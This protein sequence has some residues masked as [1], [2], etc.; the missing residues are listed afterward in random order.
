M[1]PSVRWA[2][3][4]KKGGAGS[5]MKVQCD[6]E[7]DGNQHSQPNPCIVKPELACASAFN[8]SQERHDKPE[9]V[10]HI[11]PNSTQSKKKRLLRAAFVLP[12]TSFTVIAM[13][14]KYGG[15]KWMRGL[16]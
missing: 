12:R 6:H 11:V 13:C 15:R 9:R 4:T 3:P 10:E 14:V 5:H 2:Y 1:T 8:E 16:K 7:D